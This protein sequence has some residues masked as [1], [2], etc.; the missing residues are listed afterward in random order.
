MD[1]QPIKNVSKAAWLAKVE[2]DLRGKPVEGLNRTVDGRSYTP[3]FH[4]DDLPAPSQPVVPADRPTFRIGERVVVT[5]PSATNRRILAG[6]NNGAGALEVIL[7]SGGSKPVLD[8][9]ILEGVYV[10]LIDL[11]VTDE[12]GHTSGQQRDSLR[13]DTLLPGRASVAAIRKQLGE[14]AGTGPLTLWLRT[15]HDYFLTIAYLRAVRSLFRGDLQL[16]VTVP[17]DPDW[18][19]TPT[20]SPP[21]ARPWPP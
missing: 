2:K 8:P 20:R 12:H 19:S 7:E 5:N 18:T 14:M 16:A 4:A 6:L 13:F 10:D 15:D 9:G 17:A 1:K 11:Y 3:F 21:P